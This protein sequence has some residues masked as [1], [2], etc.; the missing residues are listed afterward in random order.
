MASAK[1]TQPPTGADFSALVKKVNA[2]A[3]KAG[4]D[5]LNQ[6]ITGRIPAWK[7]WVGGETEFDGN[8]LRDVVNS[9]AIMLDGVKRDGDVNSQAILELRADVQAL[10][11]AP[12]AH[13]FP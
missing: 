1:P 3:V 10:K 2:L 5:P 9:N 13:P 6:L 8:G 11:E 7:R 4:I 12:A